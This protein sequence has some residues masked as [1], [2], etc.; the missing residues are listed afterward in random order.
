MHKHAMACSSLSKVLL[1]SDAPGLRLGEGGGSSSTAQRAG[2]QAVP[3]QA[4]KAPK[5]SELFRMM[6]GGA[7]PRWLVGPGMFKRNLLEKKVFRFLTPQGCSCGGGRRGLSCGGALGG[8]LGKRASS[9]SLWTIHFSAEGSTITP[10]FFS[11]ATAVA[12]RSPRLGFKSELQPQAYAT[13]GSELH[14]RAMLQ[15]AAML[16]P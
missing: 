7:G 1:G 4:P 12:Y 10:S 2:R 15:L 13:A 8:A 6:R 9:E 16:D 14:L 3:H 11:L 5:A